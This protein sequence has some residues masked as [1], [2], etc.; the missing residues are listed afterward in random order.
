MIVH[1]TMAC[2]IEFSTKLV[3]I[4]LEKYYTF[5]KFQM[6]GGGTKKAR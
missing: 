2:G 1:I 6:G 5:C 3:E 4:R